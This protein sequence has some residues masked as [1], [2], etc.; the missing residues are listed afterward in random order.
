MNLFTEMLTY[1]FMIRAFLV[2][3]VITICASLLGTS[4]VLKRY[5]MIGEGLSHLGFAALAVAYA[6]HL[7][8]LMIAIPVT[9]LSAFFLLH[10]RE[11][12]FIRGDAA[13]ALLCS[14]SLAIG[15]LTISLS[16]G[17]NTD[18]CNFMFGSILAMSP[19]DVTISL[20]A[21]SVIIA[22]YVLFYCP[23]FSITFDESFAASSGIHTGFYTILLS[24]MTA[25]TVVLGMR[26]MGA[27]LISSL[28]VF[29]AVTAM[30]LTGHYLRVTVISVLFGLSCF[31]VGITLSYAFSIPTGASIVI[32]NLTL[33][34][35]VSLI[36][37]IRGGFVL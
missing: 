14:S 30:Q 13:I 2:G 7:D 11:G 24:L 19:I 29:P 5:S 3:I 23:L 17:M 12:S 25:V 26:M 8:P 20:S 35:I 4:L 6:C 15:V 18:I 36:R 27:L 9:M 22:F 33:L 21:G 10:I 31:T 34:V 37:H 1:P 28:I 32:T 16:R